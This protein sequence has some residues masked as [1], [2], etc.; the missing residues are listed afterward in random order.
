[1]GLE[2]PERWCIRAIIA[3]VTTY[4]TA[5]PWSVSAEEAV[6]VDFQRDI[7]PILSKHCVSCHGAKRQEGGLRLDQRDDA[8]RGGDSGVAIVVRDPDKSLLLERVSSSDES[9]R[10]PFNRPPLMS[11]Q[12]ELLRRWIAAGA[13]W[14]SDPSQPQIASDH[15]AFQPI[16][17]SNPSTLVT[18]W[19]VNPIDGFV[20]AKMKEV[21]VRPSPRAN[22]AKLM[23]RL[24]L[25]LTGLPPDPRAVDA[26]VNDSRADAYERLV[27]RLLA[28]PHFGE[29]WGQRWLD[30]ARYADSDGYE[31]DHARPNAWRWRDWVIKSV[32]NDVPFDQFTIE[33]IAGDLVPNATDQQKLA[34]GFHR[35]TLTNRENGIDQEEFRVKAIVD[36]VNT[37]ST[38]WLGLTIQCAECHSHKYDPI[39]QHEYYRMFAIFNDRVDEA[40]LAATPTAKELATFRES[41]AEY[42]LDVQEL[43]DELNAAAPTEREPIEK[44]LQTLK[45]NAPKLEP[46]A[47]VFSSRDAPRQSHVHMRGNFLEKGVVAPPGVP[48][49]LPQLESERVID[50]L[51]LA[52]WLVDERNPLTARVEVNR[53]WQYLFGVGLVRTPNDFGTQGQ[54]PTHP[55]LLDWLAS[56]LVARDWSRKQMI[57]L[58]VT[59]ETYRQ[60]SARRTELDEIDP[61]NRLFAR[62]NR[63]RLDAE[64]VRD[65]YLAT[66]GLL[67]HRVGGPSF[68]PPLPDSMSQLGFRV[69]WHADPLPEQYRRGVYLVVRRNLTYPMLTTFD[70]PDANVSCTHRERSNTPLQ[71]LTLL[72]D[73]LIVASARALALRALSETS[74]A[75]RL[76]FA[77]RRCLARR[78]E[79]EEETSLSA[80]LQQLWTVYRA[81]TQ[82]AIALSNDGS[83]DVAE[84]VE[85]AAWTM[86]IRTIMN[87]D[88]FVTRE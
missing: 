41:E 68:Y 17:R 34:T 69:D 32:N 18:D 87:L 20:L 82:S 84:S 23:R 75:E 52:R 40:S 43:Q 60:D 9:L 13:K 62:Q 28:S 72:N 63:F 31:M 33:Q 78:P 4:C 47:A 88:E 83:R 73:P 79:A 36:R 2:L 85:L 70:R 50:R 44:R 56:E 24:S 30:L 38:V 39:R 1:M 58:I 57:R 21:G 7:R 5:L 25:D 86:L 12:I 61:A 45:K 11:S 14:P 77:F 71:S 29:R 65:Q 80:L 8:I 55:N 42:Q 46:V 22:R 51:D 81:D 67:N 10:M 64:L 26:F 3:L 15:W 66:S 74:E 59:S 54:P 49:V 6:A 37:T 19:T 35:N 53:L 76:Q 48:E 16:C 27:D